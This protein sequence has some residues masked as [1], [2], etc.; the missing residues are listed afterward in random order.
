MLTRIVQWIKQLLGDLVLLYHIV[1]ASIKGE[2]HQE[3]LESFYKGQAGGYDAFRQR[4]LKGREELVEA[5][6]DGPKNAVWID[7]GGGTG[8]NIE[9]M[10][11]LGKLKTFQKVY[12]VD[13]SASLLKVADERIRQLNW[14][15]VETVQ[16]DATSWIP[17]E[18][19]VDLITFS[20]SLTMIPPWFDCL[21][22]A[23]EIL[24]STGRIGVVDFYV[25]QKYPSTGF[26]HHSW[27][28]RTF[29]PV[30]FASDNVFLS[31]DHLPFMSSL[32]K[33]RHKVESSH[34]VPYIPFMNVPH[35][36]FVGEN[37]PAKS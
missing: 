15:N 20:Y 19:K 10:D 17:P 4:L 26:S 34:H 8:Y 13:L 35:Y 1:F 2:T 9:V 27:W 25:A 11:K 12:I 16:A 6:A 31:R 32:F 23:K 21:L 29:W 37:Q 36:I 33:R 14:T 22:H 5:V 30:W 3:R 18:K 28:T 7:M 24:K